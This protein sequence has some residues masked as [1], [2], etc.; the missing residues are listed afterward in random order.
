MPAELV[1]VHRRAGSADD[2]ERCEP[3]GEIDALDSHPTP[4]AAEE[5]PADTR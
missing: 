5:R 3:G 1:A 2:F 4:L